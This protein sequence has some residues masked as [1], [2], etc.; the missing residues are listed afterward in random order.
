MATKLTDHFTLEELTYSVTATKNKLDNTPS[1][2]H[3]KHLEELAVELLEPLRVAWGSA[4]RVSSGYRGFRLNEKVKGSKS[5]A[6]CVGYA[7]DL[8][9]ENGDIKGFKTFVRKW[10]KETGKKYDQYIDE[11]NL[12]G[13]EWVHVGIRDRKGRQRHQDLIT[14][15][16]KNYNLLPRWTK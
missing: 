15:D 12:K 9:P 4:I 14:T 3:K 6:H 7:A 16:G 8:V 13:S 2:E 11:K 10:L 5:S 1:E